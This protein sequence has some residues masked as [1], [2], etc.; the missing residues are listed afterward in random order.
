M[1]SI[2]GAFYESYNALGHGFLESICAAALCRELTARGHC[3]ERE[4]AI[5]VM[6]KDKPLGWQRLDFL[7][8]GIIIV[9][10]KAVGGRIAAVMS[11]RS[12]APNRTAVGL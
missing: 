7:I 9:E 8:D 10:V 6:Y 4:V 5:Q 3:V 1:H 2:I 11:R 12:G